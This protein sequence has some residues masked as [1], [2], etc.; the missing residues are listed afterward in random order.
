MLQTE[1]ADKHRRRRNQKSFE[2]T[3]LALTRKKDLD[4]LM[5]RVTAKAEDAIL[6][7]DLCEGFFYSEGAIRV[8]VSIDIRR[9][10]ELMLKAHKWSDLQRS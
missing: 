4:F 10:T 9:S 2:K 5:N 6:A 3:L 7:T 8:C 1:E